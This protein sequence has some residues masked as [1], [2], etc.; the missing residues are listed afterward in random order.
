MSKMIKVNFRNI[1]N[2]EFPVDTPYKDIANHFQN[3]FEYPILAVKVDND[4]FDLSEKLSK[5][6]NID[7]VDRT[8]LAGNHIYRKSLQFILVLAIKRI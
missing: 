5:K 7:F 2:M 6:C 8:S 1:A 4:I 3:Y